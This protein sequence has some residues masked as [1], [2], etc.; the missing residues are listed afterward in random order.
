MEVTL[1]FVRRCVVP[2]KTCVT[3]CAQTR[4][5]SGLLPMQQQPALLARCYPRAW[6][7]L[8]RVPLGQQ[9]SGGAL[10]SRWGYFARARVSRD[11]GLVV[12]SSEIYC[13]SRQLPSLM[14]FFTLGTSFV[15]IVSPSPFSPGCCLARAGAQPAS[16]GFVSGC[17]TRLHPGLSCGLVSKD[18]WIRLPFLVR[19][20]SVD[21]RKSFCQ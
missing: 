9:V 18:F 6:K 5:P 3:P 19:F 10:T 12:L 4:G 21:R 7:Q 15:H 17:W 14:F 8:I 1:V 11:R 2:V 13:W 20:S 16:R